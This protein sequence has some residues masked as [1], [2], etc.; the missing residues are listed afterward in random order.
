MDI[1]LVR[2]Y[3]IYFVWCESSFLTLKPI[4]R[5]EVLT[6]LPMVDYV[7]LVRNA[8]LD[9]KTVGVASIMYPDSEAFAE[10]FN[11]AGNGRVSLDDVIHEGVRRFIE[12]LQEK[13]LKPCIELISE[14]ERMSEAFS[15]DQEDAHAYWILVTPEFHSLG[16]LFEEPEVVV[17]AQPNRILTAAGC[18]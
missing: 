12:R 15:N 16:A 1:A 10:G 5:D 18:S 11:Q 13:G 9:G 3:R 7:E 2:G 17:E 14:D 6:T 4:R 8:V